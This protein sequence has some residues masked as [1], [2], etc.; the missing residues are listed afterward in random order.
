MATLV[1]S[2]VGATVGSSLGGTALGL[3]MTAVGRFAGA[4]VGRRL[5]QRLMGNG[6]DAVETGRP[7]QLR[8]NSSG[9][10]DAVATL[11]GRIRVQGHLIWA[12][13]FCE[14]STVTQSGGGGGGDG[15]GGVGIGGGD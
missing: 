10:G 1:L 15:S 14:T 6:S 9:E 7:S 12:S 2:A 5:D 8:I 3:S 13:A 11:Y 4:M